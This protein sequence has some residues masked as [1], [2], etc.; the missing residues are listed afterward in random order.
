MLVKKVIM[1]FN[2]VK[3]ITT[4]IEHPFLSTRQALHVFQLA[5]KIDFV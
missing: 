2:K 3:I 5:F 4:G 1:S